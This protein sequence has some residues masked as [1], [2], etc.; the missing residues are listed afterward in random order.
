MDKVRI[1]FIGAGGIARHHMRQ[2]K[3]I[4]EAEVVAFADPNEGSWDKMQATHPETVAARFYRDYQEMLDAEQLDAVEVHTPHTLHFA[5]VMEALDRGLHVLVEKPMVT[6]VAHAEQIVR[7]AKESGKIVLVS[8]Q[9]H[10]QPMYL[11]IRDRIQQGDLGPIQFLAALQ[12]QGWYQ[13]CKGTWRHDPAL[14][15]GGQLTDSGSHLIDIMLWTTGLEPAEVYASQEFYDTKVDIDSAIT[16][17]FKG[18]AQGTISIV[19]YSPFWW[20]DFSIWGPKA[21]VLYRNGLL[22]YQSCGEKMTQ[23]ESL[24]E[25]SNPD[26]NFIGAILGREEV[27]STPEGGLRVIRLTEAAWQSARE[28]RPVRLA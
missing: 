24:P 14:S 20:E 27:Q 9:R 12:S 25:G 19:G 8:Y 4:P 18:G 21:A 1:G 28:G 13:G 2:L 5:Q 23:P 11:Y 10:Y 16:I 6:T 3:E 22:Y 7:K 15:G 26:R 17:R